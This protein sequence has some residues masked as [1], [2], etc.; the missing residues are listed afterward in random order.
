MAEQKVTVYTV[1]NIAIAIISTA[2]IVWYNMKSIES[3]LKKQSI[4][5]G[6]MGDVMLG[7][8][9]DTV[10][11]QQDYAYPWGNLL[12]LLEKND[13]N[14]INLETTLTTS[15]DIVSKVFNFKANPDKVNTLL[16]GKIS[17]ANLANNHSKD[18]S[19]AGLRETRNTLNDA[20]IAHVGAGDNIQ[21]AQAP[22]IIEKNGIVIGVLGFTDNEPTW[23]ATSNT[24]GTNY[25]E[26]P[27]DTAQTIAIIKELRPK[28]DILIL[29]IHW[30]PNMREQPSAD[31]INFA[32]NLIDAGV[33]IIHGHS[34]HIP[35]GLE[36]YKSKLIMY[37]TGD[38]ID[39]YAVDPILRNDRSFLFNVV[40]DKAG[41]QN[42]TL[43]PVLIQN[44][45]VTTA[46]FPDREESLKKI[47]ELSAQFDTHVDI[48][49]VGKIVINPLAD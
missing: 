41:I 37:D 6:F 29:T 34:A 16:E 14:I 26:I 32:H 12:P 17:I 31:F 45:Q 47:Q 11:D 7:R 43:I 38:F 42:V 22:V 36:I 15:E 49:S 39:D 44:Y 24:P 10:I 2:L 4:T 33:D 8:T 48:N 35:Q 40:V 27:K 23:K 9:V 3:N 18:F 28:V 20:H 19:F 21:E 46:Q 25:I 5:I 30:G 1:A 13:I